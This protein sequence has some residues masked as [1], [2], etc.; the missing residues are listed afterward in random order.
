MLNVVYCLRYIWHR[1]YIW[2]QASSL[3]IRLLHMHS[4]L[5][6]SDLNNFQTWFLESPAAAPVQ[7]VPLFPHHQIFYLS[8]FLKGRNR[9]ESQEV[10]SREHVSL[11]E[12]CVRLKTA[13]TAGLNGLLIALWT[14]NLL[15]F[16]FCAC[17]QCTAPQRHLNSSKHK[18]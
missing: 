11:V 12:Y 15:D 14:F 1:W 13:T 6:G 9:S 3:Q 8:K 18:C 17:L 2:W 16:H 5:P 10:V 7:C 4:T